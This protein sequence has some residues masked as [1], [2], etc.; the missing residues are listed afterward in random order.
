MTN[1]K[2]KMKILQNKSVLT[3]DGTEGST[4]RLANISPWHTRR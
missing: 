4:C 3:I 1:N 2:L